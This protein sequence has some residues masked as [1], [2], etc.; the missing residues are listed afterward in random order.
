MLVFLFPGS[1][2]HCD[3]TTNRATVST[4]LRRAV[5]ELKM[6]REIPDSLPQ[7]RVYQLTNNPIQPLVTQMQPPMLPPPP[8]PHFQSVD[9]Y[10]QLPV[11]STPLLTSN[12]EPPITRRQTSLLTGEVF[13]TT[14]QYLLT[15]SLSH[16]TLKSSQTQFQHQISDKLLIESKSQGSNIHPVSRISQSTETF[17]ETSM[18][19]PSSKLSVGGSFFKV[20]SYSKTSTQNHLTQTEMNH[21]GSITQLSETQS[22]QLVTETQFYQ[23]YNEPALTE[24][25][26]TKLKHPARPHHLELSTTQHYL[27]STQPSSVTESQPPQ[28]Q[29]PLSETQSPLRPTQHPQ[30]STPLPMIPVGPQVNMSHQVNATLQGNTI[31]SAKPA[32]DTEPTEWLKRNTSQSP[33][34]SNDPRL[35]KM[36]ELSAFHAT[37]DFLLLKQAL[38]LS[39][40]PE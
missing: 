18:S 7:H 17:T 35:V 15:E 32:N 24:V 14:F 16:L 37:K 10:T 38:F 33:M 20:D 29:P 3:A 11:T 22:H 39:H 13:H 4:V 6:P 26:Q 34:T 40:T 2:S 28:A 36:G 12:S 5:A 19:Q 27:P 25:T 1:S 9:L 23:S 21:S 30:L 8:H 31:K